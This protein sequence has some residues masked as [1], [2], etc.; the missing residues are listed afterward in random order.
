MGGG[1]I[2]AMVMKC[3]GARALI[4][5]CVCGHMGK[6]ALGGRRRGVQAEAGV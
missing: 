2:G 5:R 1:A 4:L 6:G 3:D